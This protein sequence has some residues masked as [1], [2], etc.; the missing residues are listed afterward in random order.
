MPD[1][2]RV[3]RIKKCRHTHPPKD[4]FAI[5]VCTDLECMG[6]LVNSE[7]NQFTAK[8]PQLL[9]CQIPLQKADYHFLFY[10]SYLDCA[11][12]YPFRDDELN[13][14]LEMVNNKTKAEI[15]TAVSKAKT[16]EKRYIGLI[17]SS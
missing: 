13:I 3:Y 16:I 12:L 7:I 9:Q 5:I 10:N 6:F 15:K 1:V 8:K 11:R 14:G 17:L 2:W 4:K